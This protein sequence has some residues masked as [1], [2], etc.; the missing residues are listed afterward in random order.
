MYS[1]WMDKFM[2]VMFALILSAVV[3]LV[4]VLVYA[5]ISGNNSK[6]HLSESE[7]QCSS[8]EQRT[9]M[10]RSGNASVPQVINVCTVYTRKK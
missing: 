6:V 7:W 10:L 2:D 3:L 5:G 1:S 8:Y 9:H 4:G